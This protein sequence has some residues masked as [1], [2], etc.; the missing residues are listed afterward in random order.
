MGSVGASRATGGRTAQV[1]NG[2][3]ANVKISDVTSPE[4]DRRLTELANGDEPV[5]SLWNR[6]SEITGIYNQLMDA[7]DNDE[8]K[9][10]QA[11]NNTSH[12]YYRYYNDGDVPGWATYNNGYRTQRYDAAWRGY[13]S[14]LTAAGELELERRAVASIVKEYRRYKK[15]QG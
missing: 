14:T 13:H 15:Q 1:E 6:S 4:L 2:I 3:I 7:V 5:G 10:T 8:F 9:M 12:Q 11:T